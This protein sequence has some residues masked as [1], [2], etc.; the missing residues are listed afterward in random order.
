MKTK[1]ESL[2][3]AFNRLWSASLASNIADGLFKTAVPLLATTITKDP[4]QIAALG[5]I[6]MLPWLLFA[7]PIGTIVDRVDRRKALAFAN[8]VRLLGGALLTTSIIGGWVSIWVLYLVAFVVGA[9]EVLY[10]T[11]AQALIPKLLKPGH[12]ERG[13]EDSRLA[14]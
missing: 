5:A 3:T 2:G 7:I 6:V 10:D 1:S 11:T 8:A 13:N 14:P 4:I 12:I 9:A